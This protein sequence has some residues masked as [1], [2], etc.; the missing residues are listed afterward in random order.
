MNQCPRCLGKGDSSP[1]SM[2]DGTG[3]ITDEHVRRYEIAR[4]FRDVRV[5]TRTSLRAFEDKGITPVMLS[6]AER[7][8]IGDSWMFCEMEMFA[9]RHEVKR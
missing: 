1:C 6:K 7:L 8:G 2:C 3:Q 9:R 5:K 4:R